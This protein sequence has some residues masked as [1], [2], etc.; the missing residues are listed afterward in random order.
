[1]KPDDF[2]QQLRQQ[3][4]R[5]VPPEWRSGILD[6]AQRSRRSPASS[7]PVHLAVPWWREWLWPCPQAWAGLAALWLVLLTLRFLSA[8]ASEPVLAERPASRELQMA[9]VAQRREMIRLLEGAEPAPVS[10]PSTPGPRT[11]LPAPAKA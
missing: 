7:R 8:T 4:L 9:L 6:A 3:P 2:E 5:P 10:K 1:M 11:D